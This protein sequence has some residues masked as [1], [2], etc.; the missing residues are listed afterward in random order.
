[1]IFHLKRTSDSIEYPF[2]AHSYGFVV[3]LKRGHENDRALLAHELTH[4]KQWYRMIAL[5]ALLSVIAWQVG[6][7]EW[8]FPFMVIGGF[9]HN[10]LSRLRWYRK[11]AEVEAF[12]AHVK[13]GRDIDNA[14]Y[15]LALN[16]DLGITEAESKALLK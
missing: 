8:A 11:Y 9:A 16:Y 4:V 12:R 13:A 10:V 3:L 14:A 7:G 15:N 6:Y 5:F 1:M 2:T